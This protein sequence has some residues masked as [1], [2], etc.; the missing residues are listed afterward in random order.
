ML[1]YNVR[2][3]LLLS[4]IF[5]MFFIYAT[6]I[7]QNQPEYL[8]GMYKV[9]SDDTSP[10]RF[11]KLA[12]NTNQKLIDNY[13]KGPYGNTANTFGLGRIK[14]GMI[15]SDRYLQRPETTDSKVLYI[16]P[17]AWYPVT[18]LEKITLECSLSG[19]KLIK[20]ILKIKGNH[21]K[22]KGKYEKQGISLAK[23]FLGLKS[24]KAHNAAQGYDNVEIMID[25]N[26]K[27]IAISVIK[28]YSTSPGQKVI[29]QAI[30]KKLGEPKVEGGYSVTK[31][32]YEGKLNDKLNMEFYEDLIEDSDNIKG[33]LLLVTIEDLSVNYLAKSVDDLKINYENSLSECIKSYRNY[34][35]QEIEIE[36]NKASEFQL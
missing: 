10:L 33:N 11:I 27:V 14:I 12:T 36:K 7:A 1:K 22:D 17:G 29:S 6:E 26:K 35:K 28:H 21:K 25:R 23:Q 32:I 8:T 31:L 13:L 30:K 19:K 20:Q 24:Y 18:I 9:Q 5:P 16:T 34:L 15:L 4:L 2:S 3:A